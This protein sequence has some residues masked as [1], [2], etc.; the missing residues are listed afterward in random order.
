[1]QCDIKWHK[2]VWQR[3]GRSFGAAF[4]CQVSEG[5]GGQR[6]KAPTAHRGSPASILPSS[7]GGCAAL[8][9]AA[10]ETGSSKSPNPTKLKHRRWR[11]CL[12][13]VAPLGRTRR[14][15]RGLSC[16][17]RAAPAQSWEQCRAPACSETAKI[18]NE[19]R[20]VHPTALPQGFASVVDN[21]KC[22]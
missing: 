21:T 2:Q 19:I 7:S 22:F 5:E 20:E 18:G 17:G 10:H 1:M 12:G 16:T 9:G 13:P 14:F 8:A 11:Q 15:P 3:R 6:S 4:S